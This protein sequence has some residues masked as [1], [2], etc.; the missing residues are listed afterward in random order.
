MKTNVLKAKMKL[1]E[2]NNDEILLHLS[3]F[4]VS[5]S[6]ASWYRK[7]NGTTE[8]DRNEIYG[9]I[10]VLEL[11]AEETQDIFFNQEVS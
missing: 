11:S 7:L 1:K 6:K 10:E 4:G 2:L 5:M 3:K 8:F 9:L